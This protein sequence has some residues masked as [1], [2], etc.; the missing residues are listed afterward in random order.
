[1]ICFGEEDIMTKCAGCGAVLQSDF[2]GEEGYTKNLDNKYCERC[3]NI[4][5]YNKY[6]K[7]PDKDYSQIVKEIDFKGDLILLVTDFLNLYNLD[8]LDLK[9]IRAL[10]AGET[11]YIELYEAQAQALRAR[12]AELGETVE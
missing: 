6:L 8:E 5:H 9:S 4:T 7:V 2:P 10:R 3:F 12:L 1:M 11:D